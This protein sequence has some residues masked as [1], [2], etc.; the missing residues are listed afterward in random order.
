MKEDLLEKHGH[1]IETFA[2]SDSCLIGKTIAEIEKE[3]DVEFDHLHNG[4]PKKENR[5]P[6]YKNSRIL[7]WRAF[8]V[9]GSARALSKFLTDTNQS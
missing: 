3:Y 8:H 4:G 2:S 5:Y 6:A 9:Y 7:P 1:G